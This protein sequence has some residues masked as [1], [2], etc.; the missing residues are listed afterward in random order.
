MAPWRARHYVI[1]EN[2]IQY[3]VVFSSK[4]LRV[5]VIFF[6]LDGAGWYTRCW[7]VKSSRI[8]VSEYIPGVEP[9][10]PTPIRPHKKKIEKIEFYFD[11]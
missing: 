6:I 11:P 8:R 4:F 7:I 3:K 2:A 10:D 5:L 9:Q 1:L